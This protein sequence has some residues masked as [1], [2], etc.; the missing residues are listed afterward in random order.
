MGNNTSDVSR[1]QEVPVLADNHEKLGDDQ[2]RTLFSAW[3]P[4]ALRML[5]LQMTGLQSCG[6]GTSAA[7]NTKFGVFVIAASQS[8]YT[9]TAIF[10]LL[11]LS[12]WLWFVFYSPPFKYKGLFCFLE[13]LTSAYSQFTKISAQNRTHCKCNK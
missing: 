5:L 4:R 13:K 9:L 10:S 11:M 7:L 3:E 12:L 8:R 2:A 1:S 6:P